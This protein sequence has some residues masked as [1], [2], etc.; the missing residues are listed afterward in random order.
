MGL[1]RP[2]Q[3]SPARP[4]AAAALEQARALGIDERLVVSFALSDN[5]ASLHVMEKIG[6]R[7]VGDIEHAGL[8]HVLYSVTGSAPP[9]R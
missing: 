2:V 4:A 8:P 1:D 9:R 7:R 6:L 3:A 5:A